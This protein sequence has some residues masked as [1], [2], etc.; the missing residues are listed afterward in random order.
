M[1]A[2]AYLDQEKEERE[3]KRLESFQLILFGANPNVD[4]KARKQF[5]DSIRPKQAGGRILNNSAKPLEWDYSK[6]D[7]FR[8]KP[9]Q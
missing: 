6:M 2:L 8:A 1:E 5:Y 7:E 3:R 9:K 4:P